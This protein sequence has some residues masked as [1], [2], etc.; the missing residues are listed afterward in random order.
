MKFTA[1]E[2]LMVI[3]IATI[4]IAGFIALAKHLIRY[5]IKIFLSTKGDDIK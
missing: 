2:I 3:F 4:V 5:A 1:L